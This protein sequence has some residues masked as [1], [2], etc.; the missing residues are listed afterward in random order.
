MLV[1][2]R[3]LLRT[4]FHA[5]LDATL[6]IGLAR[7]EAEWANMKNAR[8]LNSEVTRAARHTDL[9]EKNIRRGYDQAKA[10]MADDANP[11]DGLDS[12]DSC[13]RANSSSGSKG[14][15]EEKKQCKIFPEG[16]RLEEATIS[17]ECFWT[18][19]RCGDYSH[20]WPVSINSIGHVGN[21]SD[22]F[23]VA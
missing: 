9:F 19:L 5:P 14:T 12:F 10:E 2:R 16:P 1:V 15:S 6:T 22:D 4:A 18:Q 3:L 23:G 8:P 7:F 20:A 17:G 11:P 13:E 21:R